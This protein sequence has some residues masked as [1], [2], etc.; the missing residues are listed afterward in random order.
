MSELSTSD[1]PILFTDIC[2]NLEIESDDEEWLIQS[3]TKL[4]DIGITY[5]SN[6]KTIEFT[7]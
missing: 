6:E 2:K 4:P 1:T 3:F 7:K 5:N